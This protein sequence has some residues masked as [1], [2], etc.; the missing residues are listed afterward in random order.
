MIYLFRK[1]KIERTRQLKAI[2]LVKHMTMK[3]VNALI[4]SSVLVSCISTHS[5]DKTTSE[6]E[7]FT[8]YWYAGKAEITSYELQQVRYGEM[9]KG[10][11]VL[12]FVTEPFSRSRLVKPDDWQ[13][14]NEDQINVLKLNMTKKFLTGIYPYSMMMSTFKPVAYDQHPGLLKVTTSSQEWCGHTFMQLTR[15]DDNYRLRSFSYFEKDGDTDANIPNVILEDELWTTLRLNP[16]EL[17]TGN[18]R[19]LPGSFHLRLNHKEAKPEKA[20]ASFTHIDS[21]GLSATTH[22]RYTLEYDD[23][24]L[25]IYFETSFPYIILGW[26]ESYKKGLGKTP[27]LKTTARKINT[28]MTA[29]W[30]QNSNKD[31]AFRKNLG[32]RSE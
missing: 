30:S 20:T 31:R 2:L 17:P 1:Q 9:H 12:V 15:A 16:D 22:G 23:R 5:Q 24:I 10:K 4:L 3:N 7:D 6:N 13:N 25:N 29:Y 18:I 26:D 14:N 21:S 11:A 32:L 27:G 19:L 8:N 28:I